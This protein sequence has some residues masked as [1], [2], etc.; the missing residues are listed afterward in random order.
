[1]GLVATI[2]DATL[3]AGGHK[4]GDVTVRADGRQHLRKHNLSALIDPTVEDDSTDGY[5]VGSTWI[6]AE[7]N[8]FFVNTRA[9][10]GIARWLDLSAVGYSGRRRGFAPVQER[11]QPGRRRESDLDRGSARR[12]RRAQRVRCDHRRQ[13]HQ[14]R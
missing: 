8:R 4:P 11:V 14:R 5:E 2:H 12:D 6:N 10:A 3:F 9:D 7:A 13:R 1:M